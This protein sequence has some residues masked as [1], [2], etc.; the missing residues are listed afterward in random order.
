MLRCYTTWSL[1][2]QI[3]GKFKQGILVT[4][5]GLTW[6]PTLP[7]H[8]HLQ[9]FLQTA[10]LALVSVVLVNGAV[11]IATA[12]VCQ[13]PPDTTFEEGLASFTSKLSVM[14]STGFISANHTFNLLLSPTVFLRTGR[15]D[16]LG[17]PAG[18]VSAVAPR[19][20]GQCRHAI[21]Y[22][23]TLWCNN[24]FVYCP[25]ARVQKVLALH[26]GRVVF[27]SCESPRLA[28]L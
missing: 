20:Y 28:M 8:S 21:L 27:A 26:T 7:S 4:T 1:L 12:L 13:I 2:P 17:R 15:R 10:V 11:P 25:K 16:S 19:R 6:A 14:F 9:A 24:S 3:W 23:A 5:E 22:F 18:Q